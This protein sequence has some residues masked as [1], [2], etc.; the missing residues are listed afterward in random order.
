LVLTSLPMARLH[1]TAFPTTADN[2]TTIQ[3]EGAGRVDTA[4][5]FFARKRHML[6]SFRKEPRSD[7]TSKYVGV[8]FD[9]R[10]KKWKATI[11][12]DDR[13]KI[14]GLFDDEQDAAR[15]YDAIAAK[16]GRPVNVIE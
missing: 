7:Y 4:G 16:L 14:L 13:K 10:T 6:I 15:C 2:T 12:I 3:N 1:S 11:S 8:N 9:K 5:P